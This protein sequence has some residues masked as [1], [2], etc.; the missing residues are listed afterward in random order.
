MKVVS[1]EPLSIFEVREILEKR[2]KDGELNYEQTLASDHAEKF[3]SMTAK[4][5]KK[6]ADEIVDKNKKVTMETAV[7]VM[8]IAPKN[9]ST[10]RALM[11][12]EKVELNEEELNEILKIIG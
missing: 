3:A 2:K 5:A 12:K 10:L 11:L 4:A 8:D 6:K 9:I 7:K 1:T